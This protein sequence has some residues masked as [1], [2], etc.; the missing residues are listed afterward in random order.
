MSWIPITESDVQTRLAGAELTALKTAALATGQ[1]NPLTE[2]IGQ[3]IDEM[4]G[5]IAACASNTLG[6]AG[7]IP[8]KL[9]GAALAI[10]RYRLATR[11]PVKS[12]LTEDRVK[13]NEQAIH[14]LEQVAA[15][16]FKIEE[17]ITPDTEILSSPTPHM[18][19]RTRH[20]GRDY[21]DGI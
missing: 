12:L 20:F 4:R 6:V 10:I 7:T 17:P 14:L 1:T 8:Q 9:L 21:E 16:K 18:T 11:L 19:A 2:I 13:E 15:C 5:Y 3:V